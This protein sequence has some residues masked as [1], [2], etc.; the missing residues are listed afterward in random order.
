LKCSSEG[1]VPNHSA[2]VVGYG[3]VRKG[4]RA[5]T[6]CEEY[7]VVRATFGP[8]WGENGFF[9]LCMDGTGSPSVP[10]GVC[11]INR[12]PAYPTAATSIS[13]DA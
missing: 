3:I 11:H 5:R 7:L 6:W 9:N 13:P 2:V 1:E 10:Y 8:N 4:D 12:F